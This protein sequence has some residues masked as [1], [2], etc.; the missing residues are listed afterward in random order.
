MKLIYHSSG[1]KFSPFDEAIIQV[2]N[3]EQ[4]LIVC[5][6]INI[7][8][9]ERI[10]MITKDWKLVT[11]LKELFLSTNI[12]KRNKLKEYL[13]DNYEY[14]KDLPQLHAKVI[15]GKAS[16]L[17]GSA[18][19]TDQGICL[20]TEMGVLL[21]E[22][23]IIC[24]LREWFDRLWNSGCP[25][26][27]NKLESYSKLP[28][29]PMSDNSISRGVELPKKHLVDLSSYATRMEFPSQLELRDP[30]I[31][32]LKENGGSVYLEDIYPVLAKKMRLSEDLLKLRVSTGRKGSMN[33]SE[34]KW[35][36]IVRQV[37]RH[38]VYEG[39]IVSG[40]RGICQLPEMYS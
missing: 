5:P 29:L 38:L 17:I 40:G 35:N 30:F 36:N 18:N 16:A 1:K 22:V 7:E 32:V 14:V 24:E 10:L 13:F 23:E 9:L 4:A 3:E 15:I 6:Y 39:R 31:E 37:K 21:N 8:Y 19:L 20:K 34:P 2:V 12:A 28:Y 33:S 11:D 26:D 27:H 25:C